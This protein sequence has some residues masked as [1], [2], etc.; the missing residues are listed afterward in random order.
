M[1]ALACGI[2]QRVNPA[3]G[4]P[5]VCL[6]LHRGPDGC[7][8]AEVAVGVAGPDAAGCT[9]GSRQAEVC[10]LGRLLLRHGG[11]LPSAAASERLVLASEGQFPVLPSPRTCELLLWHFD[12]E[13]PIVCAWRGEEGAHGRTVRAK[14]TTLGALFPHPDVYR[15][16]SAEDFE[17]FAESFAKRSA[18]RPQ[19]ASAEE[20]ALLTAVRAASE[21][22]VAEAVA[23]T[24]ATSACRAA[25]LL[26]RSGVVRTAVAEARCRDGG[27]CPKEVT[28]P[29]VA[30]E[31]AAA[32][33]SDPVLRLA[34]WAAGDDEPQLLLLCDRWG[35]LHA[36]SAAAREYLVA[37]GL[38]ELRIWVHKAT[39]GELCEVRCKELVGGQRD[40]KD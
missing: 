7:L 28:V 25:G 10:A 20:L 23:A 17:S 40:G 35:V 39:S 13:L 2:G 1:A 22:A 37:F 26:C 14:S 24:S 21:A 36:P 38:G 5:S 32:A 29:V 3:R 33:A 15:H 4:V 30:V 6:L 31:Q 8:L 34:P 12:P 27:A 16:V 9:P 19:E 18:A 11:C